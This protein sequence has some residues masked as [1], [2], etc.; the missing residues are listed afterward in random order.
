[1]AAR[2]RRYAADVKPLGQH[3]HLRRLIGRCGRIDRIGHRRDRARQRYRRLAALAGL[4]QRDRHDKTDAGAH[5][6][7]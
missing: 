6:R 1:M 5:S 3:D 4:L 2:S 7:V